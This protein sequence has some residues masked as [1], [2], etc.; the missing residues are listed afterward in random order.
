MSEKGMNNTKDNNILTTKNKK[1]YEKSIQSFGGGREW[2]H[3]DYPQAGI[4]GHQRDA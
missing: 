3:G 1:N 4:D 2:Q